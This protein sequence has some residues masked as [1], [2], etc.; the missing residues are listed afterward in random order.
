MTDSQYSAILSDMN[1]NLFLVPVI[2]YVDNDGNMHIVADDFTIDAGSS[3]SEIRANIIGIY[4]RCINAGIYTLSFRLYDKQGVSNNYVLAIPQDRYN[5]TI[6][7]KVAE[8]IWSGDGE[9]WNTDSAGV[10]YVVYDKQQ[11]SFSATVS[12]KKEGDDVSVAS[13]T[14]ST[15]TNA[16]NYTARVTSLRGT[17]ANNYQI[18]STKA[19]Q[20]WTIAK[21]AVEISWDKGVLIETTGGFSATYSGE[22]IAFI[23]SLNVMEG[24]NVSVKTTL[25]LTSSGATVDRAVNAGSYKI[26]I[27]GL[28]GDLS[29]NNYTLDSVAT[30]EKSRTWT[31]KPKEI[32]IQFPFG[33]FTID[34]GSR[35][36]KTT[37]TGADISFSVGF[38]DVVEKDK[39][40]LLPHYN[41]S[42]VTD[43]LDSTSQIIVESRESNS[44]VLL[45]NVNENN[46][47]WQSVVI[48]LVSPDNP[49]IAG[50]YTL[51]EGEGC[52]DEKDD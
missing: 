46:E 20:L 36:I 15:A 35:S 48:T 51:R 28:E 17:S 12:N 31:I 3:E 45:K 43:N 1:S 2:S 21:R 26:T 32:T 40:Y 33:S 37:Y 4:N 10:W 47:A 42:Y 38:N 44:Y 9:G 6:S 52:C 8:F 5:W 22:E 39:N 16:G 34:E 13:Y 30:S 29:K 27:D 49:V 18:D 19:Y 41:Y 24:D 50:N 11:H 25:T 23:P 7:R 14:D